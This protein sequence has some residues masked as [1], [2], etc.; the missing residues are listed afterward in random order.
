M[1]RVAERIDLS[2]LEHP[3]LVESRVQRRQIAVRHRRMHEKLF[4]GLWNAANLVTTLGA[5][6]STSA[7]SCS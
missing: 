4:T 3:V 5:P 2:A 1:Q 6:A 7:R